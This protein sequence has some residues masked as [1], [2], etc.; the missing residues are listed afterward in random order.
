VAD[1]QTVQ[2]EDNPYKGLGKNQSILVRLIQNQPPDLI[3]KITP[4]GN[5]GPEVISVPELA[6]IDDYVSGTA[7]PELPSKRREAARSA[8]QSMIA[9]QLIGR[10]DYPDGARIWLTR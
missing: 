2:S 1:T 3:R 9:K 7:I 8:L 5:E 6:V 10:K 4:F